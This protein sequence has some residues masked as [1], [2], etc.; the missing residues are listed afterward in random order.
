MTDAAKLGDDEIEASRAPLLDHLAEL[1]NR[2][3]PLNKKYP[4]AE[5]L[6]AC[7]SYLDKAPRDF[8][9]FEYCMLDGVNDSLAQ[10][11]AL[12]ALV[13]EAPATRIAAEFWSDRQVSDL[14]YQRGAIVAAL[15][16]REIRA[17]SSGRQSLDHFLRERVDQSI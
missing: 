14:P 10:A 5:L 8:I 12:V 11:R 3:V 1:R 6:A 4:I 9:T 17:S 7:N 2:L 15:L 16:D 13:C